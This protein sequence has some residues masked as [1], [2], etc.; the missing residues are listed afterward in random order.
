MQIRYYIRVLFT[1]I[2][3]GLFCAGCGG[4][5]YDPALLR[6][7]VLIDPMPEAADSI[8]RRV[9]P[10]TLRD[11][12]DRALYTLLR[13]QTD[14]KLYIDSPDDSILYPV[15]DF[16]EKTKD[17]DRLMRVLF[18]IGHRNLVKGDYRRSTAM[19]LEVHDMAKSMNNAEYCARANYLL[20][21]NYS[22]SYN[23][24]EAYKR[25]SQSAQD[26]NSSGRPEHALTIQIDAA[27]SLYNLGKYDES[28]EM[29]D[30]V[31]SLLAL[32]DSARRSYAFEAKVRPYWRLNRLE[33][34]KRCIDSMHKYVA[35]AVY[36]NSVTPVMVAIASGD[37]TLARNYIDEYKKNPPHDVSES[38]IYSLEYNLFVMT[39]DIAKANS[40]LHTVRALE[41]DTLMKICKNGD[42]LA[43]VEKEHARKI[44]EK[45]IKRG[46]EET[47]LT[48]LAAIVLLICV[49][50]FYQ[51]RKRHL[52]KTLLNKEKQI[53]E[54]DRSLNEQ[55][56]LL[57]ATSEA[58]A[59]SD[60]ES[61]AISSQ[62]QELFNERFETINTLSLDFYEKKEAPERVRLAILKNIENHFTKI[63]DD[64][65]IE[66]L[67]KILNRIYDNI[68]DKL[69]VVLPELKASDRRLLLLSMTPLSAKA[70][71][72]IC[73]FSSVAYYYNRRNKLRAKIEASNHLYAPEIRR[74]LS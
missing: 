8:L 58:L 10:E 26:Y 57:K 28:E 73:N 7:E 62:M 11:E 61:D 45:K 29:L 67:E 52:D 2:L 9:K 13:A 19:G 49:F 74:F 39:G 12:G 31:L 37:S 4:K 25:Y 56:A 64:N 53:N 48:I 27:R 55:M 20:G 23:F 15:A 69:I 43:E 63:A 68:A 18:Q 1:A 14:Y 59:S 22:R 40:I 6:V 42:E 66:N 16:F 60:K 46:R 50:L 71:C 17:K 38:D 51:S 3:T 47:C 35:H 70:I 34:A 21:D 32:T 72:L 24:T 54:L 33:E 44:L 30:S 5:K 36:Q 65:N 41:V